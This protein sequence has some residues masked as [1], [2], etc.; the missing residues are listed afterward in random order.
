MVPEGLRRSLIGGLALQ[1]IL[2]VLSL[3]GLGIETRTTGDYAAW[4]GPIFLVLTLLIFVLGI[5]GILLAIRG[6]RSSALAASGM[7]WAAVA[8]VLFDLSAIGGPP[9]PPGPLALSAVVLVVCGL[10]FY[11]SARILREPWPPPH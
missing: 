2:F 5:V 7:A 6:R 4:A 8:I 10:L 1:L 3:P 11:L 9:D